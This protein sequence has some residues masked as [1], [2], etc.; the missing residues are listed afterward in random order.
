MFELMYGRFEQER[1]LIPEAN[2]VELRYEDLV[3]EPLPRLDEI[4]RRL[5]LGDF[6]TARP[7]VAKYLEGVKNY[8]TNK[9]ELEERLAAKIRARCGDYLQRYGYAAPE[10][11][12]K[13]TAAN[14]HS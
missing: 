8:R 12:G 4:Y 3:A 9:Y 7:A 14:E 5:N 2:F 6:E 11:A 10:P 1:G 13:A